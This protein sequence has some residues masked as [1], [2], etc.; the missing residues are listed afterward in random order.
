MIDALPVLMFFIGACMGSFLCCQARRMHLRESN[1]T[2]FFGARPDSPRS[3]CLHCGQ[4]L[5][6]YDNIPIVSWLFLKGKCRKC[7]KFIGFAEIY[8]EI[9]VGLSFLLLSLGFVFNKDFSG[10]SWAIFVLT[11]IFSLVLW[12]LAIYDGLY[13]RLLVFAL[14]LSVV[15]AVVIL[16]IREIVWNLE[17]GFSS[18]FVLNPIFSVLIL[19]GLY[20]LLY[21]VSKGKWVG[22]GDWILGT[23]L[24]LALASPWLALITLFLSNFLATVTYFVPFYKS[25]K[26][27]IPFGPFLVVAYIIVE[28]FTIQLLSLI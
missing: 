28:T 12:F 16:V 7:H 27:H 19:G 13:M 25:K 11:L 14:I 2:L 24:G 17:F 6:W 3:V 20:L 8:S 9:G 23:T 10:F 15:L 26:K 18:E 21:L 4:Q 1:K 5:K 22:D